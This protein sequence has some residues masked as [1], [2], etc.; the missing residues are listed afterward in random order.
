VSS[1][2]DDKPAVKA[3]HTTHPKIKDRMFRKKNPNMDEIIEKNLDSAGEFV[4]KAL[5][6]FRSPF[7]NFN[8]N[9]NSLWY[10]EAR[11]MIPSA[12]DDVGDDMKFEG[13]REGYSNYVE[14]NPHIK[15][16]YQLKPMRGPV[17]RKVVLDFK[18]YD[19]IEDQE[20]EEIAE[21][22]PTCYAGTEEGFFGPINTTWDGREWPN[23]P[24]SLDHRVRRTQPSEPEEEAIIK[25]GYTD[26]KGCPRCPGLKIR[27]H[28]ENE[29]NSSLYNTNNNHPDYEKYDKPQPIQQRQP[30]EQPLGDDNN[31]APFIY[32]IPDRYVYQQQSA[33]KPIVEEKRSVS[34]PKQLSFMASD[35]ASY[36]FTP[37]GGSSS[38]YGGDDEPEYAG[39]EKK[40]EVRV[41]K[42][43]TPPPVP[44][45]IKVGSI[46]VRNNVENDFDY[47]E[48]VNRDLGDDSFGAMGF[49]GGHG[50]PFP[51]ATAATLV[52][53]PTQNF[54]QIMDVQQAIQRDWSA[55]AAPAVAGAF[56]YDQPQKPCP[57]PTA[58]PAD[59][60]YSA[61]VY[62]EEERDTSLSR[63]KPARASKPQRQLSAIPDG[64][65]LNKKH[66][67]RS[68]KDV[69]G[70]ASGDKRDSRLD[71]H[72]S[73]HTDKHS[74]KRADKHHDK[75]SEKKQQQQHEA[76]DSAMLQSQSASSFHRQ[77]P[78]KARATRDRSFDYKR[79]YTPRQQGYNRH[80]KDKDQ[81]QQ[82]LLWR[83][84]TKPLKVIGIMKNKDQ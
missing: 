21:P 19:Q 24:E 4:S 3:P 78:K 50:M 81:K 28:Y 71:R 46:L 51:Q 73:K 20:E 40:K 38:I 62:D 67:K 15:P 34:P 52:Q 29:N 23:G 16:E 32:S 59:N 56:P 2:I 48:N 17:K 35:S 66:E 7:S 8:H 27:D 80:A 45:V 82:G 76:E 12:N 57:P 6:G 5:V 49:G 47:A 72:A 54:K 55:K 70:N 37:G 58:A 64:L 75:V 83:A 13:G 31:Y 68:E 77:P 1:R 53:E 42:E 9:S 65:H 26:L 33:P 84:V 61:K 36:F 63:R 22:D 43:P 14:W 39:Y 69:K 25:N 10:G 74:D 41:V 30:V 11:N 60:R 79:Q 44:K 18:K